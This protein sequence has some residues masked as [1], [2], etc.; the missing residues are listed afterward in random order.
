MSVVGRFGLS[1]EERLQLGRVKHPRRGGKDGRVRRSPD[2]RRESPIVRQTIRIK[3]IVDFQNLN[4]SRNEKSGPDQFVQAK[5]PFA[6][7]TCSASCFA[8]SKRWIPC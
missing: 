6:S 1:G 8:C 3:I 5:I 4:H 7:T 2:T